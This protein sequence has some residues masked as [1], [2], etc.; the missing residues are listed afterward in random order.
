MIK[1]RVAY[2]L[3]PDTS[4]P[5]SRLRH[6]K[7]LIENE[8]VTHTIYVTTDETK[9][10]AWQSMLKETLGKALRAVLSPASAR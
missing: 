8:G 4:D 6:T 9:P 7:V 3:T 1:I 10:G 2:V 5:L